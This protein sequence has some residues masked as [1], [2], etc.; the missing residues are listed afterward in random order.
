[1][2]PYQRVKD[3]GGTT[4]C[5]CNKVP[6]ENIGVTLSY[7]G[8][9]SNNF[10]PPEARY[11][12]AVIQL[13][14]VDTLA[15]SLHCFTFSYSTYCTLTLRLIRR[16]FLGCRNSHMKR[17]WVGRQHLYDSHSATD[18]LYASVHMA[19]SSHC[20]RMVNISGM[21][22]MSVMQAVDT[23]AVSWCPGSGQSRLTGDGACFLC[24]HV[25]LAHSW[26]WWRDYS[27][28]NI[29]LLCPRGQSGALSEETPRGF[30]LDTGPSGPHWPHDFDP[31]RRLFHLSVFKPSGQM[32]T[33]YWPFCS[34]FHC[35]IVSE[36]AIDLYCTLSIW[37]MSEL[38]S[39]FWRWCDSMKC[40][41]KY[42]SEKGNMKMNELI[43]LSFM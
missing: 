26:L 40:C 38:R 39:S 4:Y 15:L 41:C 19:S 16:T 42:A 36:C 5:A 22:V 29:T 20:H 32:V 24:L 43:L 21:W 2:Q 8:P 35:S 14:S 23:G 7:P 3:E 25:W 18:T 28:N 34:P 6:F 37:Q 12:I 11:I 1:M 31:G 33:L 10:F 9:V 27:H 30:P 17:M 13:N